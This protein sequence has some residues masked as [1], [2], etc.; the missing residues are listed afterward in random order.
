MVDTT[1]RDFALK[2]QPMLQ[3]PPGLLEMA[4]LR[5]PDSEEFDI[6]TRRRTSGNAGL[7][8]ENPSELTS[9]RGSNNVFVK[10]KDDIR[11]YLNSSLTEF[12]TAGS[13]STMEEPTGTLFN[14]SDDGNLNPVEHVPDRFYRHSI[15]MTAIYCIAY[16]LVFVIGL[17]GNSFVIAVV[18]R[19]PRMRTVTNFFIVNLAVADVLVIVFCLPATLVGNILVRKYNQNYI[20]LNCTDFFLFKKI[21]TFIDFCI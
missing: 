4:S 16:M 10:T 8:T 3:P 18:Y 7:T 14:A 5:L 6:D 11:D 12:V 21:F 9:G 2:I 13:R 19:S 17:I 20:F 1:L 15:A